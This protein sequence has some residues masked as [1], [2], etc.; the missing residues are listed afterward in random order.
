MNVNKLSCPIF[1]PRKSSQTGKE[2]LLPTF[3][4]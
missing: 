4:P 1:S 2:N 3:P